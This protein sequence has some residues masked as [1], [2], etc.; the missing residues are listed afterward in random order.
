MKETVRSL[1]LYLTI[2]G[3]L[4]TLG[5]LSTFLTP[6]MHWIDRAVSGGGIAVTIS[7]FIAGFRLKAVL[8]EKSKFVERVLYVGAGYSVLLTVLLVALH[9]AAGTPLSSNPEAI[10]T[11]ARSAVGLLITWYLLSNVKR[12]AAEAAAPLAA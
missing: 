4:G 1:T 10:A 5:Q 7:Y 3:I 8:A 6:E 2:V 9:A 12:L 11:V